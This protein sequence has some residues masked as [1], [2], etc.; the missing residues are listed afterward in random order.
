M[1]LTDNSNKAFFLGLEN[2][3][4]SYMQFI[5]SYSAIYIK[6]SENISHKYLQLM[7]MTRSNMLS[8]NNLINTFENILM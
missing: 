8:S 4:Y 7:F 3:V 6:C 1:S 2:I 5:K